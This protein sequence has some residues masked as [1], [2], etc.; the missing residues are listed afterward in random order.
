M[1][2]VMADG[3]LTLALLWESA[4][5][6]GQGNKTIKNLGAVKAGKLARIYQSKD[7]LPSYNINGIKNKLH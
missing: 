6:E 5:I 4:W 2:N 3:A 1:K 7:F